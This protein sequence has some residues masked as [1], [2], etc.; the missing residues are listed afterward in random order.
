MHD[1][2]S[3]DQAKEEDNRYSHAI[4]NKPPRQQSKRQGN[5]VVVIATT[6]IGNEGGFEV[7]RKIVAHVESAKTAR[8]RLTCRHLWHEAAFLLL[9]LVHHYRRRLRSRGASRS[10]RST[11]AAGKLE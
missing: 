8:F 6:E 2:R 5:A 3:C 7:D 4:E 1:G 10:T 9:L 11:A